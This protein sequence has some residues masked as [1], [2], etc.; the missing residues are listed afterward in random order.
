MISA[1]E[2]LARLKEGNR[3]FVTGDRQLQQLGSYEGIA[4]LSPRD[5]LALLNR[6]ELDD[7]ILQVVHLL[8]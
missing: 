7:E 6:L 3:R 4:I 8:A 1:Q 2:A 5:F